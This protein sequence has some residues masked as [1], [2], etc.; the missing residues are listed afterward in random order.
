MLLILAALARSVKWNLLAEKREL[1][2][3]LLLDEVADLF[4][5]MVCMTQ[6]TKIIDGLKS[7]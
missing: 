4:K 2:C 7:Q 6:L 5:D 1:V 3:N